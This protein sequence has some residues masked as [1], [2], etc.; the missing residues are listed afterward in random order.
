LAVRSTKT[1][2]T[3]AAIKGFNLFLSI[4]IARSALAVNTAGTV[5][6]DDLVH[7]MIG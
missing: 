6:R 5:S 4:A 1:R 7:M 3:R 2:V